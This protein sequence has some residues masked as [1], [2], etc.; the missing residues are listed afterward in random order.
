MRGA[1]NSDDFV[2]RVEHLPK[3][4]LEVRAEQLPPV[5]ADG[6]LW[7]PDERPPKAIEATLDLDFTRAA[8]ELRQPGDQSGIVKSAF[9]YHVILLEARL[10]ELRVPLEERRELL[11]NEV[12]ARRAKP[13]LEALT[14]RMHAA[15]PITTERAIDA[16]T[17]LVAVE[18]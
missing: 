12:L 7:D 4:A 2:E 16:L 8:H 5:T 14:T 1:K 3:Q 15:T 6:R 18:P 9:G 10:P 11:Q 17:A 13:V